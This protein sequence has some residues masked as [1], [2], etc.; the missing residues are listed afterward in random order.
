M[1]FSG[2]GSGCGDV[3]ADVLQ[4]ALNATQ[5]RRDVDEIIA[6]GGGGRLEVEFSSCQI[7]NVLLLDEAE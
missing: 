2:R 5:M 6:R 3:R 7:K 1:R 4:D